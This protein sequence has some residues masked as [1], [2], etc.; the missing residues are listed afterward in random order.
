MLLKAI[1][2]SRKYSTSLYICPIEMVNHLLIHHIAVMQGSFDMVA[3]A[4]GCRTATNKLKCLYGVFYN[5]FHNAS[6]ANNNLFLY[7]VS[8]IS[9]NTLML[10]HY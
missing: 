2:S 3:Q 9:S 4:A 10:A 1:W 5:T 7:T 8:A 6:D